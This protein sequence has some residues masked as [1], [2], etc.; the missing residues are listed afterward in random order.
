[1][2][3]T[4]NLCAL[5]ALYVAFTFF[6]STTPSFHFVCKHFLE[7]ERGEA[8]N[9]KEIY[10]KSDRGTQLVLWPQTTRD[11]T[12]TQPLSE[13]W[14]RDE[15]SKPRV[16]DT[17]KPLY[18]RERDL[19]PIVQEASWASGLFWT[20]RKIWPLLVSEP[21]TVQPVPSRRTEYTISA[22]R[23][24]KWG[25]LWRCVEKIQGAKISGS[26]P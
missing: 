14:P 12:D 23:L 4:E 16:N 13:K 26:L 5:I 21:R 8:L 3:P 17:P 25:L 10:L 11:A 22:G 15:T 20:I 9:D 6:V 24:W 19:L 18:P 7:T 1:M 2:F